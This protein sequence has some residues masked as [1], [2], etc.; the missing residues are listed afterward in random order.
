MG[1]L[2]SLQ[3]VT[4]GGR[5]KTNFAIENIN[6]ASGQRAQGFVVVDE[7]AS[8]ILVRVPVILINGVHDGPTLMIA[9]GVHGDDLNTVPMVWRITETI[10]PAELH[11]QLIAVPVINPLAYEAGTHRT[12]ED[13]DTPGF[14]GNVQGTVSQRIGYH[15]Y[16]K[17]IVRANYVI[18][19]HG[20]S[21]NATLA[22]L[23]HI[24]G[25]SK[26]ETFAKTKAMAE[27]FGPQ[28]IVVQEPKA[29][30]TPRGMA[31]VA[32]RNG[33]PGI[34]IGMG[35]MGF[36]ETDTM[37][38]AK[39]VINVMKYLKMLDGEPEKAEMPPRMTKTELYQ[40][41]PFGGGF[42]PA[43][44]AGQE[45]KEG[46]L[47]GNV[48]DVFGQ[49]TGEIKAQTSGIVDAIRFYPVVSAGDWIA[50]IARW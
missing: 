10:D 28:L 39:G 37:R 3:F 15:V 18:D 38:G 17:L 8:G 22:T 20:G 4:C 49:L 32:S 29:G 33:S 34:Y 12:P 41:T 13:N 43:V 27:A 45:V 35:Q 48:Y 2:P 46:D 14:P 23:A 21:K 9:S 24:D 44:L 36:N 42:F 6:A 50:S 47:L 11:G 5:V 40:N 19:M 26:P 30:H 31:Q 1:V 16:H 25:G 7:S